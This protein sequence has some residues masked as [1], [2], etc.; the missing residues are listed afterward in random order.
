[1]KR[2]IPLLFAALLAS[3]GGDNAQMAQPEAQLMQGGQ[4]KSSGAIGASTS[5]YY[6]MV[7]GIYV[8]Y[9]GRPA[10]PGGL[11]FFASGFKSAGAHTDLVGTANLYNSN[12]MVRALVEVFS[13]SAE[14]Q[15]LYAGDNSVFIDAIYSNLFNRAPDAE[16][17][18]F[19]VNALNTNA[20]TRG[21]AAIFIMA[22]AQGSDA[23]LIA[24]KVQAASLF[25]TST[26][27]AA[28]K[29]A[30]SGLAA[31][32]V[33]RTMLSGVTLATDPN[34]LQATV[35]A[36]LSTLVG[37]TAPSFAQVRSII[38]ARCVGCHSSSPKISGFSP[39][40]AG[41][42][43]DTENQI[44]SDATRIYQVAGA[45]SS[46]PFAN[47]TSMTE[48]ERAIIRQWFEAGAN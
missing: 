26:D 38:I 4:A 10:D 45:G 15:A 16:G 8:A 48:E 37:P 19:W 6:Q 28:E 11:D 3:C 39:A 27:T 30:Y 18:A 42:R 36:T 40:P 25:T 7:Q 20:M 43:Y 32:A 22:S 14:S 1:M 34:T 13:G 24:R 47:M 17:K 12:D 29:A 21:N 44:R 35:D 31:N 41:I 46:M 33:V 9:F 5:D 2:S 23:T